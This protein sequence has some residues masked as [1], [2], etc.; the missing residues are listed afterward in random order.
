ML[1]FFHP[2][3]FRIGSEVE[4]PIIGEKRRIKEIQSWKKSVSEAKVGE[5]AAVLIPNL[6]NTV[7][8][9][10]TIIFE[11]GALSPGKFIL[12]KVHKIEQFKGHLK[13]HSKIHLF[14][15][16]ETVMAECWFL[17]SES[18]DVSEFENLEEFSESATHIMMDLSKKINIRKGQVCL[19]AKLDSQKLT[20]CRF[21][22]FGYVLSIADSIEKVD[23]KR[24]H[25]KEKKGVLER[26]DKDEYFICTGVFKKEN[27]IDVFCGMMVTV[28]EGKYSG[29]IEGSFGKSGKIRIQMKSGVEE[30]KE[31]LKKEKVDV[32]LKLK[33]Y[34]TKELISYI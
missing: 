34:S 24:F 26:W 4:I 6:P 5:R 32:L 23:F 18:E 22:F 28:D 16:F 33:K 9:D 12:I 30:L 25:R 20:E 8:I 2:V 27:V 13:T 21:A 14:S 10:R 7:D 29:I 11:Q 1:L 17:K 19:A 15:G 31:K 3:F